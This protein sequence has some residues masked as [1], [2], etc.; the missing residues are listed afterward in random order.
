MPQDLDHLSIQRFNPTESSD[1]GLRDLA[2]EWQSNQGF[3]STES[4]LESLERPEME[5]WYAIDIQAQRW[6][7]VC[8]LK[9]CQ[10]EAELLYIHT[11]SSSRGQ[12]IADALWTHSMSTLLQRG[13]DKIFLEVR[14][15]NNAAIQFYQSVGFVRT[16]IRRNYY[17]DGDDAFI[18]EYALS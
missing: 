9:V 5:L 7:G 13:V 14:P 1:N 18:F 11:R 6:N 10:N 4:I 2:V 16:G 15:T 17:K 12:G 3:W 8:F